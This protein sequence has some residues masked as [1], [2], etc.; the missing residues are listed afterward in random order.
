MESVIVEIKILFSFQLL[1]RSLAQ[2]VIDEPLAEHGKLACNEGSE[3]WNNK[4]NA[5]K[6]EGNR[7]RSEASK[8]NNSATKDKPKTVVD[9]NEPLPFTPDPEKKHASREARAVEANA[10]S[11]TNKGDLPAPVNLPERKNKGD[12]RDKA[13]EVVGV[14][15]KM[16]SAA[17]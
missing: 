5:I 2:E 14:S 6:E 3:K 9:H 12:A 11:S 17:R 8:G 10:S 7:K 15:G 16:L 1:I 13:A 4:Q